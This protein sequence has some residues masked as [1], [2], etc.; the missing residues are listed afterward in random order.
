MNIK[1]ILSA[2]LCTSMTV[3]SLNY[4]TFAVED[5]Q[6]HEHSY[7]YTNKDNG[8]HD[9]T[10]ECMEGEAI[11]EEHFFVNGSCI[12]GE[13][14]EEDESLGHNLEY[15]TNLDGT[16]T[17]NCTD[18]DCDYSK[19]EECQYEEITEDGQVYNICTICEYIEG[20][21]IPTPLGLEVPLQLYVGSTQVADGVT[22]GTGW[23]YNDTTKTLTLNSYSSNSAYSNNG[24][25]CQIYADGDLN[26]VLNGSNTLN[27]TSDYGIYCAGKLT[28]SGTGSIEIDNSNIGI[29]GNKG[30]SVKSGSITTHESETGLFSDWGEI[31]IDGGTVKTDV[32]IKTDNTKNIRISGATVDTVKIISGG[33]IYADDN[34]TVN[35][36]QAMS[37]GVIIDNATVTANITR[38]LK[39]DIGYTNYFIL[40]G[41]TGGVTVNSGRL[42][43]TLDDHDGRGLPND[44]TLW[45]VA[46][47]GS[48]VVN[49]GIVKITRTCDVNAE[50]M[51]G[52]AASN[53]E[54]NGGQVTL[55]NCGLGL[56][57][58]YIKMTA[59]QVDISRKGFAVSDVKVSGGKLNIKVEDYP[60]E[61]LNE[62]DSTSKPSG[63]NTIL[64]DGGEVNITSAGYGI[65][66]ACKVSS[67]K[68]TVKSKDIGIKESSN[69]YEAPASRVHSGITFEGGEAI[70]ESDVQALSYN[71]PFT[72]SLQYETGSSKDNAS[73]A[74]AYYGEKYIHF[75]RDINSGG[76]GT[77][78]QL[79][80]GSTQVADGVTSGTGWSYN[81]TTKTLTLNSYSSNSA[82]SNNGTSCQIYADGDLNVV[83]N[84]SN[85]LNQTSDY[86]IYCA[87][88]LTVSGTGS[89]EIDNSNIG[90]Y[91]NKGISV[92]SG[93][94]TTHE[95]ETGLFSDW[96]EIYIDGGTVKTDVQIKTDNTKNI[97]ISGATVDT[98]KIISGGKI[99]ADDNATVNLKQAMSSGV[100]ID[101]A[102]VTANIT[103]DLK[104][105]IGYTNYFILTGITGGVTVNS[106]RLDI[107]LDDHDGRGLPNDYTLWDVAISGSLVVNDGIVKITRTCDVNAEDMA[108]YA[109]SNLEVNGGQVTLENCGLGLS[110]SYIKMTAGQVDISRK[111]FAVSDVKVSGGKLNIKVEDYPSE[112]LNEYDSTSKPS[113]PNTILVDGGEVNITSAGYG[114]K[115]ACKVSSGKLT[116]KSKDIGIKES[117]NGYE[118]PA[119]R[120]HSGITFEGGE[121]IIE[122]DVQALSYNTYPSFAQGKMLW[123][124]V[125]G[126]DF[127]LANEYYGE[128]YV[129][130]FV[131]WD[132]IIPPAPTPTPSQPEESKNNDENSHGNRED[133]TDNTNNSTLPYESVIGLSNGDSYCDIKALNTSIR[134]TNNQTVF[135]NYY[136]SM[137]GLKAEM[138]ITKDLYAPYNATTTWKETQRVIVWKDTGMKPGDLVY[139]VW[140]CQEAHDMRFIPAV[141]SKTGSVYVCIPCLGSVST[142]S[143]VKCTI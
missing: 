56:S 78:L 4:T 8:T 54:V 29:Y 15:I 64:V 71:N 129:R 80:V 17:I 7:I 99:Y 14:D 127:S 125:D 37:S 141:V 76:P 41:I 75:A 86:G 113:G 1:K 105:D 115:G 97:R 134:D 124:G 96:G 81:D 93:S 13:T 89:I 100:I 6:A 108:G 34:A 55:E 40:T 101:N 68:L 143:I 131:P 83:L 88:K 73:L 111:G 59:G 30:I 50:D 10:C 82:Y 114:I 91:G 106:G 92:K 116:V 52:Y 85:T 47:S 142:I 31:Y 135:A 87:G 70:I 90:I 24:T 103:R 66:G 77:G 60:S 117:S 33:K 20:M 72:T 102:T 11:N 137:K 136:A 43:I 95:S 49:D 120:V 123:T 53:L 9:K 133:N 121:A 128:K 2:V 22:S 109:A 107:T 25:S 19:T 126:N 32:Q 39:E 118:A 61:L 45:D 110:S 5:R 36:K 21:D 16:H 23:S 42:D 62:Y 138:V 65:K 132:I 119:S 94:I 67:G 79:Y 51:A 18:I 26:V 38:D 27:Q 140:Y 139:V 112:L 74:T 46:I 35:L 98:V 84:G 48:L 3:C 122:S 69:G 12:C 44:Y 58:S 28:V 104:E 57:S 63:P 130:V